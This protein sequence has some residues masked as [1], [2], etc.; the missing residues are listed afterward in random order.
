MSVVVTNG[1]VYEWTFYSYDMMSI[2]VTQVDKSMT[3][4]AYIHVLVERRSRYNFKIF[5]RMIFVSI[6]Q[7][8]VK[9][10]TNFRHDD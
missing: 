7:R 4:L 2:M 3:N 6:L 8:L 9:K 10:L 1:G 5:L